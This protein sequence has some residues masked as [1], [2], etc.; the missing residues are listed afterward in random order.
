MADFVFVPDLEAAGKPIAVLVTAVRI[1]SRKRLGKADRR[2]E[3]QLR[4]IRWPAFQRVD[5]APA[6][7][8]SAEVLRNGWFEVLRTDSRR[9]AASWCEVN[10]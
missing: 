5:L 4:P 10:F 9:P 7:A 2:P 8:S 1:V 6:R 3:W